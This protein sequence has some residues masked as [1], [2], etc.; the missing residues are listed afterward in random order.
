ME[1]YRG[2][3]VMGNPINLILRSCHNNGN[4]QMPDARSRNA[5]R[6][7]LLS[8]ALPNAAPRFQMLK[9]QMP[10]APPKCCSQMLYTQMLDTPP[11]PRC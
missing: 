7:M 10:D 6:Q 2:Y 3:I 8:N 5:R 4:A 9:R 11:S 1:E